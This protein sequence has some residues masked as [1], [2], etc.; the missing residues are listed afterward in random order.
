[1]KTS[2]FNILKS[3]IQGEIN[4]TILGFAKDGIQCVCKIK[5]IDFMMINLEII[6]S[7]R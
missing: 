4:Y 6:M 3:R 5:M 1:M 2:N 7:C